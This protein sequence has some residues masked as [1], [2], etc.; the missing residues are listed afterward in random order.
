MRF[1]KFKL[2]FIDFKLTFKKLKMTF[3]PCNFK[4]K[5][6]SKNFIFKMS[7]GRKQNLIWDSFQEI[8]INGKIRLNVNCAAMFYMKLFRE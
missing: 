8:K 2:N 5:L 6:I 3:K 4:F 7:V 1:T